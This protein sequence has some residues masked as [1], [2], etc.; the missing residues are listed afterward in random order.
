MTSRK[1]DSAA[2][3]MG[4]VGNVQLAERVAP[5]STT[6]RRDLHLTLLSARANQPRRHFDP[7][8]LADLASSIREKG[9]L[10]P[11][12]VR[13][14]PDGRY[15]VVAGERRLRAAHLAELTQIP[16]RIHACSDAEADQ[17]ALIENLQRQ[18]LN[19]F[20]DV[21]SKLRLIAA[22]W[23]L[24]EPETKTLLRRLRK[25]PAED[26]DKVQG[27]ENL[28]RL[29]GSEQWTSFVANGLTVLDLPEFLLAAMQT[30][31][32]P[33]SKAVL[34]ARAPQEHQQA[35]L[36]D[37]VD[38]GLS[39]DGLRERIAALKPAVFP[40]V[41]AAQLATVRKGLS[42]QA[43]DG[44]SEAKKVRALQLLNQLAALFS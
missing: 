24:S 9:V 11:L 30:G 2:A 6:D 16:V 27:L 35:L 7:A 26:P 43:I 4:L 32:L 41:T 28:F 29:V 3:L 38:T 1:K 22:S 23:A 40:T 33:Y 36:R 5:G 37:V 39:F 15:E 25:H 20:E 44:L 8:T 34:I 31:K 12:L 21:S 14:L 19:R 13:P 42:P 18:N 10:Q 17:L